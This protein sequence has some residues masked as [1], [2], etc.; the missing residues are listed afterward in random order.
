[1]RNVLDGARD[2]RSIG[3]I[4]QLN[5][6][7][8]VPISEEAFSNSF[9]FSISEED[10]NGKRRILNIKELKV[11]FEIRLKNKNVQSETNKVDVS[12]AACVQYE[13]TKVADTS[14]DLW[15]DALSNEVVC[16][17][18]KQGFTVGV[19]DKALTALSKFKQFPS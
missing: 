1:M 7:K 5:Y 16:V 9:N 2:P 6:G 14:C 19:L 15:F 4:A 10:Q 8:T 18:E 17:C 11:N 3:I 12:D 13:K